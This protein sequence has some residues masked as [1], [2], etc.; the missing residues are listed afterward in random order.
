VTILFAP[1]AEAD[2]LGAVTYLADRNPLAAQRLAKRV[3]AAVDRL[4]SAECE[5]PEIQ[6]A[7]GEVVRSWPVP[8][9]RIFYRRGADSLWVLRIY[10]MRR[11]PLK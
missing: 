1:Q 8:P 9:L 6:L 4:A 2:F 5:G 11:E 3:F 7:T 10:D